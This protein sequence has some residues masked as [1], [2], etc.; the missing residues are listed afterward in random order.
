MMLYKV[1]GNRMSCDQATKLA[2]DK[3]S[4]EWTWHVQI[5]V[6]TFTTHIGTPTLPMYVA[7]SKYYCPTLMWCDMTQCHTTR[8]A[9][10]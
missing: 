1:Q 4:R 2:E 5:W 8:Y 3:S 9:T 10:I 7:R 6:R